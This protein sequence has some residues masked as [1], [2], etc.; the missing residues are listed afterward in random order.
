MMI[1]T[2]HSNGDGKR[3]L[4]E[5]YEKAGQA[6]QMAMDDLRQTA[7]NAR[8]FYVQ[9]NDAFEKA[10]FEHAVRM[11]KLASVHDEIV[12]IYTEISRQ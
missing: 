2:V 3:T 1:P 10:V 5:N 12:E 6:I 9:G 8:N 11:E 4:L 7:P